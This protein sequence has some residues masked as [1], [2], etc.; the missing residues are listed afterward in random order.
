[1]DDIA[2]AAY[3]AQLQAHPIPELTGLRPR[4]HRTNTA[5]NGARR[6]MSP[7]T[8]GTLLAHGQAHEVTP[9]ANHHI[10]GICT[11]VKSHPVSYV[12]GHS[13]CYACIRQWLETSWKCPQ[14]MTV[15]HRP[16][17]RH[18]GDEAGLAATYPGH[19]A[20]SVTYSWAGLP[21]PRARL[22]IVAE[23]P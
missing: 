11:G 6:N 23:T 15:M 14:C 7:P 9:T 2:H 1:M 20:D 22:L 21:F 16:P 12:C 5:A 17:F 13:H 3:L 19:D 10:C 18:Y 8:R 4:P